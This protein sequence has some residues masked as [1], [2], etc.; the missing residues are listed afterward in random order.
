MSAWAA[1]TLRGLAVA[2]AATPLIALQAS[3]AP[4]LERVHHALDVAL[5]PA[6]RRL[7]VDDE[8]TLQ[9]GG[10]VAIVLSARFA[11]REAALDGR[12]L[13]PPDRAG[14]E[15]R[16]S[17]ALGADGEH[18][19]LL[20]YEGELAPLL[21]ADHRG[22]LQALPAMAA[23]RGSYLPAGSG[24]YPQVGDLPFAYRLRLTLPSGQR[25]LVPGTRVEEQGGSDGYRA[26]F[27]FAQPVDGIDLF[28]G[29]YAVRER[30]F[31]GAGAAPIRLR[32][33]FHPEVAALSDGYL[34][35][36]A[37]YLALYEEWI[38]AYPFPEFGIVSSPLPT[39]FGMPTLAYLGVDVL[40]LPFI[41]STSLGHEVLHNWWANGVYVD[42]AGGNWAEGLTTFMADYAYKEREG[43]AAAYAMRLDWLRDFAAV[44]ASQDMPLAAF[45]ARSHGA[46]QI[47]GYHKAAYVFLM[48]RDELG[49]AAFD[50]GLRQFWREQRARRAGWA[51][52]R[53][54]F[55]LAAQRPLAAFFEQWLT[56]SGAP[57]VA[58][59]HAEVETT[60][61]GY[62]VRVRLSQS[63]PAYAL[64]IPMLLESDSGAQTHVLRLD[65]LQADYALHTASR[66]RSLYLD[67]D[68]RLFRHLAS[69]ELPPILRN[70][71]LD[72]KLVTVLPDEDAHARTSARS[73]AGALLEHA[74]R[75]S[76]VLPHGAV[77]LLVIGTDAAVNAFLSAS[78]LPA[79]P[80]QVASAGSGRAWTA[81][82]I[83]GETLAVVSAAD[84]ASL[85]ALARP[86]PHYGRQSWLVFQGAQMIARGVWPAQASGWRFDR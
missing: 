12:P 15:Q 50:A 64:R 27:V 66:P 48:L 84:A 23:E 76:R 4:A 39:G 2:A 78:G 28:A 83:N 35:A 22:V 79:A 65:A 52:L 85:A 26:T 60:G 56:R 7:Q 20:R 70:V 17:L 1:R 42:Y 38:G 18:R 25:G 69:G 33:W 11:V 40:R 67:P 41:K 31:E 36:A 55:E 5:D 8:I 9:G 77:P 74:P 21:Q 82:R 29:P 49:T 53:H 44:P 54:A 46:S 75:T 81:R 14:D 24:W 61:E 63:P 43:G 10:D 32:T 71:M 51:D 72:P 30:R 57:R 68:L 45:T 3:S 6:A 34:D 80:P 59:E 86:L 62:R 47:V 58:I 37:G 19:L 16:W 13:P 73:V